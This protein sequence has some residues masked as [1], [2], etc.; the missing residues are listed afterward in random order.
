MGACL[1][2]GLPRD[3][4]AFRGVDTQTNRYTCLARPRSPLASDR[5][6]CWPEAATGRV[7]CRS[8]RLCGSNQT[9]DMRRCV[10]HASVDIPTL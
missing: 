3:Y 9:H 10:M 6:R 5:A 4:T 1:V 2:W 8:H 7:A